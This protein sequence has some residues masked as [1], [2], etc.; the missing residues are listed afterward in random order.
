MIKKV[1]SHDRQ[2]ISLKQSAVDE[3]QIE[4]CHETFRQLFILN[5]ALFDELFTEQQS[6][7]WVKNFL[8]LNLFSETISQSDS[9]AFTIS[10]PVIFNQLLNSLFCS[11]EKVFDKELF[12]RWALSKELKHA[13]YLFLTLFHALFILVLDGLVCIHHVFVVNQIIKFGHH[14][15]LVQKLE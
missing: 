15:L 14:I 12:D 2:V 11:L 5:I 8:E 1:I 13:F 3:A 6:V 10:L 4:E 7:G 9:V